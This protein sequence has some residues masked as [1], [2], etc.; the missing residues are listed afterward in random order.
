MKVLEFVTQMPSDGR[1]K[2]P[3]DI[4]AQIAND[5]PLRVVLVVGDS[6]ENDEWRRLTSSRFLEGYAQGDE[7]YDTI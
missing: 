5:D 3:P 7:V 1:L 6:T 2:V 4:A